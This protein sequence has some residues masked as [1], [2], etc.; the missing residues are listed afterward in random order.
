MTLPVAAVQ[1]IPTPQPR[2][3]GTWNGRLTL[4]SRDP[5]ATFEATEELL[6]YF[7]RLSTTGA[8]A[9]DFE[10][11][12]RSRLDL[13]VVSTGRLFEARLSASHLHPGSWRIVLQMLA[14]CHRMEPYDS[15]ALVDEP[16]ARPSTPQLR[17]DPALL[18]PYPPIFDAGMFSRA[19][20]EDSLDESLSLSVKCA[21]NVSKPALQRLSSLVED[22]GSLVYVG[23]FS[24]VS[25]DIDAPLLDKPDIV[26]QGW[27]AFDV[28]IRH[29]SP[30][31]PALAILVNLLA[32]LR[33]DLSIDTIEL[34]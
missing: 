6:G 21:R 17:T 34:E 15:I 16:N 27:S 4:A 24:P 9:I 31:A 29:W 23:G 2:A 13:D 5:E 19:A 22:W 20:D 8:F 12:G 25:E 18:Q 32:A 10:H 14:H 1:S 11:V 26:R 7:A 28:A 33:V 30:N 3:D